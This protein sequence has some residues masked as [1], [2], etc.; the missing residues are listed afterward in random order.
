[1]IAVFYSVNTESATLSKQR[2]LNLHHHRHHH[3]HHY[4]HHHHHHY[5]R[6]IVI[7]ILCHHHHHHLI[8]IIIVIIIIASS[9]CYYHH[10]HHHHHYHHLTTTITIIITI[11]II[12]IIIIIIV[13]NLLLFSLPKILFSNWLGYSTLYFSLLRICKL[14]PTAASFASSAL[15]LR[16]LSAIGA[17][18]SETSSMSIA[19][20]EFPHN[21]ALVTVCSYCNLVCYKESFPLKYKAVI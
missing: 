2:F 8:I 5:Y 12:I 3:H 7:I 18:A 1:M 14:L 6:V 19:L 13:T 16:S 15:V 21:L 9:S 4:H 20:E 17:A 11:I 10:Q